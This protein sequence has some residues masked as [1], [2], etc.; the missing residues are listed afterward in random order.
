MLAW[1]RA[2]PIPR[3]AKVLRESGVADQQ[4]DERQQ[5]AK[6]AN[7]EAM[8][9]AIDSPVPAPETVAEYVFA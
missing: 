6:I 9:F 5:R 2:D 4:L 1:K 7:D 3:L 8:Q